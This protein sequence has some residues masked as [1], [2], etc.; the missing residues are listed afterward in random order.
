M[1]FR[2]K[3]TISCSFAT[4]N[5]GC[6]STTTKDS[7]VSEFFNDIAGDYKKKYSEL[8]PFHY[9]FFNERLEKCTEGFNYQDKR[10]LDVGAGTGDLYDYLMAKNNAI[11]YNACDIA[12]EMLRNSNIPE[13]KWQVGNCYNLNFDK[14]A[15]DFIYLLGVT[16]YMDDA[17]LNKTMLF[18]KERLNEGGKIVVTFT[19][20][21]GLDTLSRQLFTL[22]LRL[23]GSKKY[24][25]TQ[26]FDRFF[27][28]DKK[29]TKKLTSMGFEVS[30]RKYLNH[31]VFPFNLLLPKFSVAMAKWRGKSKNAFFLRLFSSDI[32][33]ILKN[34]AQ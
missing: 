34:E 28:T 4:N 2:Q 5:K 7:E 29:A 1:F 15:Y 6:M 33:Y 24:V 11:Q 27:Y 16:T 25:A 19:N 22:P 3:S 31:T 8:S 32:A 26:S 17:E 9:Y 20:A 21:G 18:L 10:V 23:F 12:E 14:K 30:D 13:S